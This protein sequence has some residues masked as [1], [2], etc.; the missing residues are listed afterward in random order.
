M[1]FYCLLVRHLVIIIIITI[2]INKESTEKTVL[3]ADPQKDKHRKHGNTQKFLRVRV[4]T[5]PNPNPK[6]FSC[7]NNAL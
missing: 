1:F 3:S 7:R 2:I 5:S 4:T 6:D